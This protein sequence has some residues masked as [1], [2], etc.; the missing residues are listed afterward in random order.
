M[1]NSP[2]EWFSLLELARAIDSNGKVEITT[3]E[4][5]KWIK[6][7]QQTASRRLTALQEKNWVRREVG[8]NQ[9]VI[10]ITD[11]GWKALESVHVDLNALFTR[12]KQTFTIKGT[13]VSGWG[14]GR[15]YIKMRGYMDQ[16]VEKLGYEPFPGTLN[17]QLDKKM[18]ILSRKIIEKEPSIRIE[19]FKEGDRTYGEVLCFPV[20]VNGEIGAML[21]IRRTHHK[22]DIIEVISP[23]HLRE[24]LDLEDGA[25]ITIIYARPVRGERAG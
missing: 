9:Q 22:K 7:S 14:D 12:S 18:D 8:K 21:N 17:I 5:A 16:F 24:K 3:V 6:Q 23:I 15:N 19:P 10:R 20:T 1:V 11:E 2:K 4:F 13:L 25:E